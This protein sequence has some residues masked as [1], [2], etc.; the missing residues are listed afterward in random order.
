MEPGLLYLG[1]ERQERREKTFEQ[2]VTYSEKVKA[3]RV[4]EDMLSLVE[5]CAE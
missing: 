5:A 3:N 4:W 2:L 1:R